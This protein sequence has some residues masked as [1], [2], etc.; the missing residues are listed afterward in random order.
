[1]RGDAGIT[2]TAAEEII[3][4]SAGS[5]ILTDHIVPIKCNHFPGNFG[6]FLLSDVNCTTKTNGFA[7]GSGFLLTTFVRRLLHK[8]LSSRFDI[9]SLFKQR[10]KKFNFNELIRVP[11]FF[12]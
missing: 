10:N 8:L 9:I 2:K 12:R 4:K 3:C 11:R 1:M 6:V 7:F 5:F